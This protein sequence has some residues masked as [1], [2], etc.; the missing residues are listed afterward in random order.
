MKP[1]RKIH[2]SY[3]TVYQNGEPLESHGT[4]RTYEITNL[5]IYTYIYI[6]IP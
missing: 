3:S 4:W 5:Y 1:H 2:E 6:P